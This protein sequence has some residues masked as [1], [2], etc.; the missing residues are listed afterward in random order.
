[1]KNQHFIHTDVVDQTEDCSSITFIYGHSVLEKRKHIWEELQKIGSHVHHKWLYIGD[2][3][4]VLS[5]EDKFALRPTTI[6]GNL[7]FLQI[8]SVSLKVSI[9]I[10]WLINPRI[11]M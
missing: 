8:L 10:N 1:M 4:Q 5:V 9:L 2:F 11:F 7:E 3:N 6:P